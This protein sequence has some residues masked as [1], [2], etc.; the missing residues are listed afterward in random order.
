MKDLQCA[1]L[2]EL[3]PQQGVVLSSRIRLARNL[4]GYPFPPS[5]RPGSLSDVLTLV[6]DRASQLPEYTVGVAAK[7]RPNSDSVPCCRSSLVASKRD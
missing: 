2:G 7:H 1:W 5:C 6:T 3:G 4:D